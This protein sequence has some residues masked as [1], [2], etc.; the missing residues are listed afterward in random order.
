MDRLEDTILRTLAAFGIEGCRVTGERGVWVRDR[1]IAS[2][3]MAVRRW[4]VMHGMALNVHPDLRY[5]GF[6]NPCG[7]PGLS[8]TSMALELG[9]S[10]DL[11]AV[12]TT[13][14]AT[15]STT[16]GRTITGA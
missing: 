5:F 4:V 14:A 11:E 16:F 10:P 2:I 12:A 7:H 8:M 9:D 13:F 6:I 3:G 15:F 1:K